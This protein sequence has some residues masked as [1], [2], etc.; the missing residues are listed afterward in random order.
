MTGWNGLPGLCV[1]LE[2]VVDDCG[3]FDLV[4]VP[5]VGRRALK[6]VSWCVGVL[7]ALWVTV[8]RRSTWVVAC[9]LVLL[10]AGCSFTDCAGIAI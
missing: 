4:P 5:F 7:S 1:E 8:P 3:R 10:L 6:V 2:A 9:F